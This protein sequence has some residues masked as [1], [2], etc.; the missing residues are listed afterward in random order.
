MSNREPT[1]TSWSYQN[2]A[3]ASVIRH[4]VT[5]GTN[6]DSTPVTCPKEGCIIK[7]YHIQ[8][9]YRHIEAKH[10]E[11]KRHSRIY[12]NH[13][14]STSTETSSND[15][16]MITENDNEDEMEVVTDDYEEA[17]FINL[18]QSFVDNFLNDE[19]LKV[20]CYFCYA[21]INKLIFR[22]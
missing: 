18:S 12:S 10:P 9:L 16:A 2:T 21:L 1:R 14:P 17:S 11:D 7:L 22:V 6:P 13:S 5:L 20:C 8:H 4:L 19:Y 15:V 3:Y